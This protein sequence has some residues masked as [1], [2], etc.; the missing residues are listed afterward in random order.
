MQ[1]DPKIA[2][3][4]GVWTSVLLLIGGSPDL[5]KN[6]FPDMWIVHIV[7]ACILLGKINNVLLT[8]A[9]GFSSVKAGPLANLT[10]PNNPIVKSAIAFLAIA[11]ALSIA[12]PARALAKTPDGSEITAAISHRP[13][14]RPVHVAAATVPAR[15]APSRTAPANPPPQDVASAIQAASLPDLDYAIALA[16]AANTLQSKVRLQCYQAIRAAIAPSGAPTAPP[17]NP[18][19]VTKVEQF[20]EL[21]DGLQPTSPV[22]VNCAGAA[23]LAQLSV[24]GFINAVVSG[25]AGAAVLVPK[26]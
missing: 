23:Q 2:F 14:A 20:A 8:A 3:Y 22:F 6:V 7:A 26:F 9:I 16:T 25:V 5:L 19:L 12:A 17:P 18:D 4:F 1:I 11:A 21:V 24:L 13:P 10:M 15:P